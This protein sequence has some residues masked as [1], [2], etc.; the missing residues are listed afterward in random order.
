[1]HSPN[2]NV[3]PD[4]PQ[5]AGTPASDD[6]LSRLIASGGVEA[7]FQP[8]VNLERAT[9]AGRETLSRP[10]KD[11]GYANASE[12]FDDGEK[13]GRLWDLEMLTRGQSFTA[14]LD[15]P[16][17]AQLFLNTTPQVMAD[18][19]FVGQLV[20][21][22][23]STP[24]LTPGR[25]VIEITERC[26]SR[27]DEDLVRQV[28]LLKSFGFEIAV[29]DV[30]AGTSGLNRIM[31]LRPRW[32]KLDR[33]LVADVQL[34]RTRQNLIRFL[35]HF[36]RM[37][38]VRVIAEGIERQEEL[39][40]LL[41]LGVVYG[42]G[43]YLARPGPRSLQLAP[44]L[45]EWLKSRRVNAEATRARDPRQTP[46]KRYSRP[47][48]IV[49]SGMTAID[50]A[51]LLLR[52]PR[53]PGVVATEGDRFVGWCPRDQVLRAAGDGRSHQP[54]GFLVH[55]D[56]SIV[57]PETS[58]CSALEF[59][60]SRDERSAGDPLVLGDVSGVVGIATVSDLLQAAA[61]LSREVQSRTAPVTGLPTRVRADE[62]IG[63]LIRRSRPDSTTVRPPAYD[64]AVV[65]IRCFADFN[66]VF[67]FELGDLL[68]QRLVSL[69][70][71]EVAGDD[72][73]NFVAHLG[74][75]RFLITARS[76]VLH[77]RLHRLALAFD[78]AAANSGGRH[79]E[80]LLAGVDAPWATL[81]IVSI[82]NAFAG[83]ESPRDLF[84]LADTA[85]E[86]ESARPAQER[87]HAST[88]VQLPSAAST[89]F[90]LSA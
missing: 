30:G 50:V 2:A 71:S 44:G 19:R 23:R 60:C 21:S 79:G 72:H 62:H 56:A 3:S 49:A 82:P 54:V 78:S 16:S 52:E 61:T 5:S 9:I 37:S 70:Q 36:A 7:V 11:S 47:G 83:I 27:Y 85:R 58:I 38:G 26:E 29:D 13:K 74:D 15:W 64:A 1:M 45:V 22:V 4:F 63:L 80:T 40:A 81:R 12:L 39:A 18:P 31:A 25:I 75:D 6:R 86:T 51:S 76:G 90:R 88:V 53:E 32:L 48:M 14:A 57:D 66:A 8:I 69:I 24:G 46:I 89:N 87:A 34:D 35:L 84:Q 28:S 59:G 73:E 17:E 68:L 42:Q 65:D 20:E 77:E 10:S 41:D 43:F 55:P 67:G 33:E